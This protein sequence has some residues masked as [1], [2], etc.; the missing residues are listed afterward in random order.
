M[1]I[2]GRLGWHTERVDKWRRIADEI[3]GLIQRDAA[4]PD[5]EYAP[6]RPAPSVRGLMAAKEVST[7]TARRV[8]DELAAEG[9]IVKVPDVGHFIAGGDAVSMPATVARHGQEI[10]ELRRRLDA[11]GI[12][13]A[14]PA[15]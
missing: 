3:I 8:L 10:A 1:K 9:W 14:P 4:R 2:R 5:G 6:G 11:A 12:P 13:P 7:T 15:E